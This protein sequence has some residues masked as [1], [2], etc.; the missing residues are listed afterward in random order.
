MFSKVFDRYI[1][2]NNII[3]SWK[4]SGDFFRVTYYPVEL[5]GIASLA[6]QH[7]FKHIFYMKPYFHINDITLHLFV[8]FVSTRKVCTPNIISVFFVQRMLT[9]HSIFSSTIYLRHMIMWWM[10]K[11]F[12]SVVFE[13]HSHISSFL[14]SSVKGDRTSF[15]WKCFIDFKFSYW[16]YDICWSFF[17]FGV[18]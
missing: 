3:V 16:I 17:S 7:T 5:S 12:L 8:P 2:V 15:S 4:F 18:K 11:G 13:L 14:G 10:L 9:W 6:L 1:S